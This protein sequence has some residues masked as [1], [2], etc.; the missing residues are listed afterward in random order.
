MRTLNLRLV[1]AALLVSAAGTGCVARARGYAYADTPV[2]VY[3]EPPPLVAIEPNVYVVRDYDTAVYYV[4]GAY[5][6][7]EGG[8]WYRAHAWNRGWVSVSFDVV[9]RTIVHREHRHYIHYKGPPR[10]VV[11]RGP[12]H[13]PRGRRV[14]PGHVRH[15]DYDEPRRQPVRGHDRDDDDRDHPRNRNKRHRGRD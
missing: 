8:V 9:P 7:Y 6:R 13:H 12:V 2:V 10:A 3:E 4:G 14:P 11:Q 15:G 5:W 1:F